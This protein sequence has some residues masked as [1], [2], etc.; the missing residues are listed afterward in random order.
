MNDLIAKRQELL[1]RRD[2]LLNHFRELT[3][4]TQFIGTDLANANADLARIDERILIQEVQ[5]T[6]TEEE[7]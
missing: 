1:V 7:K 3:K 2:E 6:S 4:L 5:V